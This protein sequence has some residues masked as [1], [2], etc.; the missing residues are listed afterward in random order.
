M[1]KP[2]EILAFFAHPDDETMLCGGTL[3]LL[4]KNGANVHVLI[5]T[6]GEGGEL[7]EPPV[8]T[9]EKLG[10]VREDE[11]RCAVKALGASSLTLMDYLDPL[12]GPEDTLFAYTEELE[13]LT[14]QVVEAIRYR[15]ADAVITHGADGEYGHPAHKITHQAASAAAILLGSEAPLLY[16]VQ[17][18]FDSHPFPF[19]A[20]ESTPAHLIID[21]SSVLEQKTEAAMCHLTQHA[22]FVRKRSEEEGRRLTVPEIIQ[23]LESLH[24]VSPPVEAGE[25]VHD[26]LA[27]LLWASG[28][29]RSP[30]E[31]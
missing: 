17:G 8:T 15:K 14:S 10:R 23:P 26:A 7:G 31:A 3:A 21:V 11:L 20:N 19:I 28:C 6:R 25:D 16:T 1:A 27:D 22:L 29:A 2:L 9:R 12:V 18:T 30:F 5:A 4:A 24:R 13:Q